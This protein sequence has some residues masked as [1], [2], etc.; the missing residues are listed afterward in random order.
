MVI[1]F[2]YV[3]LRFTLSNPYILITKLQGG[4][5][6]ATSKV[7]AKTTLSIEVENDIDINGNPKYKKKNFSCIND[8]ATLDQLLTVAEAIKLVLD[9]TAGD[10]YINETSRLEAGV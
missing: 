4:D 9:A 2:F 10:C 3:I 6:M 7:L 8:E 5:I 1:R